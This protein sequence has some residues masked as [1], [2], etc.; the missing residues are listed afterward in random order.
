MPSPGIS[1]LRA[2]LLLLL[3]AVVG[4]LPGVLAPEWRGTEGRRVQ[5]AAEMVE[6]ADSEGARAW[7]VPTL[8]WEETFAKPPVYYWILAAVMETF[9]LRRG[10]LRLPSVVAI[11]GV[12]LLAWILVRR[13]FGERAAWIAALGTVT[14]PVL[15]HDGPYAEIDPMFAAWTAGSLMVLG[16]H[17]AR[18]GRAAAAI[19]GLL[20]GVALLIKGP[21]YF[22]FLAPTLLVWWRRRRLGGFAWFVAP[23]LALPL[24]YYVPLLEWFVEPG[25]FSSVANRESVGRLNSYEWRHVLDVPAYL[26][27]VV[28]ITLPLGLWSVF[29]YRGERAAHVRD[30]ELLLRTC[31]GAAIGGA[32]ILLL[33]P[34]RATRYLLPMIPLYAVAVAPAVAAWSAQDAAIPRWVRRLL[35]GIGV[36]G[37]VGLVVVPFLPAPLPG[38]TPA[39]CLGLGLLPIWATTRVRVVAACLWVPVLVAWTAFA[40]HGDHRS[41]GTRGIARNA[42][43]LRTELEDR[44]LLPLDGRLA[45][46]GH[47]NSGLLL[48]LGAI[49]PGDE[50]FGE[51]PHT[52]WLLVEDPYEE[53]IGKI[54]GYREDFR[55]Q[56]RDREWV[57]LERIR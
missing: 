19:A 26:L 32:M 49:P 23:M 43:V 56:W 13:D 2:A 34:G 9:D 24:A 10:W 48:D 30:D 1:T 36:A 45:T 37:A 33:F 46:W 14:S 3:C 53:P 54:E 41:N 51:A 38:R 21:P 35:F 20:G 39:L 52:P 17:L 15:L 44:G 5:I 22:M 57:L 11:W 42:A 8:G 28:G 4:H 7:M 16:R 27:R 29:E 40:D 25:H 50:L 6:R 12:S 18:P 31:K 47:M 55:I